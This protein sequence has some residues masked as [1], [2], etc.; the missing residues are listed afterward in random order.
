MNEPLWTGGP[1]TARERIVMV[2]LVYVA[3]PTALAVVFGVPG[4][5]AAFGHQ[6]ATVMLATACI[7]TAVQLTYHLS[8][9]VRPRTQTG[10][11]LAHGA[12]VLVGTLAGA[13]V[14]AR[15]IGA[16]G[17][18]VGAV[19]ANLWRIGLV[20]S[21]GTVG[22]VFV[23]DRQRA[24]VREATAREADARRQALLAELRVLQ[25][26]TNPH[27]LFNALN[28]VA[29]LIEEDPAKAERVLERLSSV[30]R[31]ALDAGRRTSVPLREEIAAVRDYLH[32]EQARFEDRLVVSIEVDPDVEG[33]LVPPFLLQP[34]V[35]NA[36]CH[37]V[38]GKVGPGTVRVGARREGDHLVL[39]VDDDGP[40]P[41]A[42]THSGS[43]TAVRDLR[44]R[45]T[46]LYGADAS[47][48]LGPAPGGGCAVRVV[49]PA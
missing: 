47:V 7:A 29:A 11:A 42:S 45:L 14:A 12:V 4:S 33:V 13:E 1:M 39:E 20:M 18:D 5:W 30:F 17:E 22:A 31:Y 36:V 32:V 44:D 35:E 6:W 37:G 15:L 40:G 27:F 41:G 2:V 34:L 9:R 3:A 26:R 25:S 49:V 10:R 16:L 43:G 21:L 46:L 23:W 19:R 48:A 38:G 24:R 28:A 8:D